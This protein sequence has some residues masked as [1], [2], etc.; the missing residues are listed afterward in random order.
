MI[1]PAPQFGELIGEWHKV[2]T[3]IPVRTYDNRFVWLKYVWRRCVCK[4]EYLPG[5][6][7]FWWWY[8]LDTPKATSGEEGQ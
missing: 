5:E 2:F 4:H 8:S 1:I 6:D 3:W 7:C